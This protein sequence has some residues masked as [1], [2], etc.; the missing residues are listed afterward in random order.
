MK[1]KGR[2]I[3]LDWLRAFA[4]LTVILVH[5]SE[6]IFRYNL[7]GMAGTP[8][9]K[10]VILFT[11]FTIGRLGVPI[12]LMMSGY[13]LLR[14]EFNAEYTKKFWINRWLG[15]LIT[16]EIWIF[17]FSFFIAWIAEKPWEMSVAIKQMLFI[18][19]VTIGHM[20]YMPMILGLYIFIPLIA[21]ALNRVET[22]I[23][24]F[25][26]TVVALV[27]TVYPTMNLLLGVW[28]K[29]LRM[30]C[31]IDTTFGGGYYGLI[32]VI[33]YMAYKG[34]FKKIK[35]YILGILL[36]VSFLGT[37]F[38]QIWMYSHNYRYNVWYDFPL[39]L[40]SAIC[41]FEL[42]SRTN[43]KS[44]K[45]VEEVSKCS[46]GIYLIHHPIR[47]LLVKY[48]NISSNEIKLVMVYVLV[49]IISFAIVK[50]ISYTKYLKKYLF[51][52]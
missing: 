44:S 10:Q 31:E 14:R 8:I 11:L 9:S 3:W 16:T 23:L 15:L 30:R 29:E 1:E 22:S 36:A 38:F 25:P 4:I 19:K 33:G 18:E 42:V 2:V 6:G 21:N 32:L 37:V 51:A 39:L 40:I 47:T 7:E 28:H 17:V 48:I 35:S 46:F 50:A 20:W 34:T 12:F 27:Y 24:I 49:F 43:F 5:T 13:L 26:V 45:I 52:M 41:I